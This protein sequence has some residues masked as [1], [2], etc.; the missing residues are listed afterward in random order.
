M[1]LETTI[2]AVIH[3]PLYDED[4]L[5]E[6]LEL[7]AVCDKFEAGLEAINGFQEFDSDGDFYNV[8]YSVKSTSE[9]SLIEF[10]VNNVVLTALAGR[11][12]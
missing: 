4:A 9:V 5:G 11:Q 6:E 10:A 1:K 3:I 2:K 8:V 7:T 12:S